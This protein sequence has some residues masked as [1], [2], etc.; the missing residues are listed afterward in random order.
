MCEASGP[1]QSGSGVLP[2]LGPVSAVGP[3]R[4][5]NVLILYLRQS[6]V[7]GIKSMKMEPFWNVKG[8]AYAAIVR[9]A[10]L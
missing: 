10:S 2:P 6:V 1:L 4:G 8:M 9:F 7:K 3:Q 5:D